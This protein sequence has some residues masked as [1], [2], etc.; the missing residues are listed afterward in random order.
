MKNYLF[1]FCIA[2]LSLFATTS[3]GN[4]P[5]EEEGETTVT[6]D[7]ANIQLSFDRMNSM[8]DRAKSSVLFNLITEPAKDTGYWYDYVGEN[9]GDYNYNYDTYEYYYVGQGNG[10]YVREFYD[11]GTYWDLSAFMYQTFDLAENINR[12]FNFEDD[13][14]KEDDFQFPFAKYKGQYV[15]NKSTKNWT[16]NTSDIVSILF[17]ESEKIEN[18]NCELAIT[19]YADK[20]CALFEDLHIFLPTKLKGY[21]KKDSKELIG[22]DVTSDFTSNGIPTSVNGKVYAQPFN[23]AFSFA[24]EAETRYNASF[25]IVDEEKAE[26]NLSIS[27]KMYIKNA[28]LNWEEAFDDN[29][30]NQIN[31]TLTQEKLSIEGIVDATDT[32][33]DNADAFN[34]SWNLK[35]KWNGKEIGELRAKEVNDGFYL[36][37]YYKDG[38]SENTS[39]YYDQLI[40]HVE[41]LF[42]FEEQLYSVGKNRILAKK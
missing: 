1:Y 29:Y 34:N 14:D 32:D 28:V 10:E 21:F 33:W 41:K 18:N 38:T 3:C 11:Y 22:F 19:E 13:F 16:K 31:F 9:Q 37:I 7:K 20:R 35:V 26:N 12:Q 42:L 36:Y 39:L 27:G 6:E 17:P 4:K 8:M 2:V 23:M 30:I 40:A 5:G 25:S 15:W 24:Q